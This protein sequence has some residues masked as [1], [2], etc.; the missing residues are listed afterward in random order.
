MVTLLTVLIPPLIIG[1]TAWIAARHPYNRLERALQLGA[2]MERIRPQLRR[3][4]DRH[5]ENLIR[6]ELRK[7]GRAR[8]WA[9]GTLFVLALVFGALA[10]LMLLFY[11][12]LSQAADPVTQQDLNLA[13]GLFLLSA[14]IS[15][16]CW[17]WLSRIPPA[18]SDPAALRSRALSRL[19][20]RE[21]LG[22]WRPRWFWTLIQTNSTLTQSGTA[23]RRR[24]A[25][26]KHAR[27]RRRLQR[28]RK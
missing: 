28:L 27:R 25:Q 19:I 4:W 10:A 18:V 21:R 24:D 7:A 5:C 23:A 15:G 26:R 1:S 11:V 9:R 6:A 2:E 22:S 17:V 8:T 20:R 13:Y 3:E 16:L 12:L 14:L